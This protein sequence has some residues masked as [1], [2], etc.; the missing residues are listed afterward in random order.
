MQTVRIKAKNL[1]EGDVVDGQRIHMGCIHRHRGRDL[2]H[3]NAI[4]RTCVVVRQSC[5]TALEM[6]EF[7]N[8]E[9]V[10]VKRPSYNK[11]KK[12]RVRQPSLYAMV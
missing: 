2:A 9:Y 12:K 7:E 10:F 8:E 4:S 6:L 11:P 1:R 3:R 5:G